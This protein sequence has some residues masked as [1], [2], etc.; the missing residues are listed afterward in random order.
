M[1]E[2]NAADLVLNISVVLDGASEEDQTEE[3][4][5]RVTHVLGGV[6]DLINNGSFNIDESVRLN[7]CCF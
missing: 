5:G 7:L 3:N 4:L 2:A 1:T 6:A